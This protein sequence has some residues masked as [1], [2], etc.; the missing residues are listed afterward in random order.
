MEK[1]DDKRDKQFNREL[2]SIAQTF[3][4]TFLNF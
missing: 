1:K 2:E 3:L 4:W